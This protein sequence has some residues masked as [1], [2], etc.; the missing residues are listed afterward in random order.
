TGR[1]RP[2]GFTSESYVAGIEAQMAAARAAFR[3]SRVIQYANFMPG[4]WLPRDDRG[5]L[6]AVYAFAESLGVGVGGPDLRPLRR[7]L[8]NHS[9]PLIAARPAG[10]VAGV[11]VQDGNLA[12]VDRAS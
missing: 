5:Y 12:D 4:E 3:R 9:Y 10:V 2:A 11:A 1:D 8:L 6:R 7:E